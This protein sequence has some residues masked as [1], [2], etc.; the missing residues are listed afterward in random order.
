MENETNQPE[1]Q[2]YK[3]EE[4]D[5]EPESKK[6]SWLL[7][8]SLAV[9][10]GVA[11]LGFTVFKVA[12]NIDSTESSQSIVET[13]P[14]EALSIGMIS[15]GFNFYPN[16]SSIENDILVNRQV[17]EGLVKFEDKTNIEPLLA[18]S[19]TNP[20]EN[21]WV[22]KLKPN[23]LFHSG[24]TM[25]AE[26]VVYSVN[27]LK[28]NQDV[29]EIFTST[30]EAAE[31]TDINEVT[32]TTT[33]PDPTLLSKLTLVYV[34]DSLYDG[35]NPTMR[36]TGP[37]YSLDNANTDQQV[38]LLAF[39]NYHG[40]P[41]GGVQNLTI[42]AIPTETESLRQALQSQQFDY[43]SAVSSVTSVGLDPAEF[44]YETI[45]RDGITVNYVGINSTKNSALQ[46]EDVRRALYLAI[47]VDELLNAY[48]K[49][50]MPASQPVTVD[51]PG[52]N[53]TIERP[54]FNPQ[55]AEELLASAG[56][57]DG[58]DIEFTYFIAAR[59]AAQNIKEQLAEVGVNVILDEHEGGQ[60]IGQKVFGSGE[61][62]LWFSGYTPDINDSIDVL[63]FLF[64]NSPNYNNQAIIDQINSSS[65]V[66]SSQRL[67]I[68]QSINKQLMDETALIPLYSARVDLLGLNDSDYSYEVDTTGISFEGIYFSEFYKKITV[69]N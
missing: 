41:V 6:K 14:V 68:L 40:G 49:Q 13:G 57:E 7:P 15:S 8:V 27:E 1:E 45:S 43:I 37:Y 39:D 44:G 33:D 64:A 65:T 62:E 63:S 53:P 5:K 4:P 26:D 61:V 47:D 54:E 10:A 38:Q 3:Q 22:F 9:V 46:N 66:F 29:G 50:G 51:V 48:D 60:T 42:S 19:W 32:I 67:E 17:F 12:Q 35:Q 31:A 34:M 36:G 2:I 20:D 11:I 59:P 55:L 56:Y 30:I 16:H 23:V 52:Y 58:L 18:E 25:T 69:E 24:N 21:T 28:K